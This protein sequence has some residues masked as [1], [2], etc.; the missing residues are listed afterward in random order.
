M[1]E[2]VKLFTGTSNKELALAVSKKLKIKLEATEVTKFSD[3]EIRVEIKNN[4]RGAVAFIIQ[5][6][7]APVND[8]LME[9]ILLADALRR[10]SV[11]KIIAVIPYMGYSRQDRRPGYARVPISASVVA[12]LIESVGID[13]IVTC[14]LHA[15]Q[16]Q[17]FYNIAIDNISATQL[18]VGDIYKHWLDKNAVVVS[19]DAGGVVRARAVAKHCDNLDL[20]IVDKRRQKANESEVMNIIG[21]VEN[22]TAIIVDDMCDTAGTLGKAADALIEV[23]GAKQVVA[24]ITHGVLS[25]SAIT[26]IE[27]SKL[28]ELVITN[29]IQFDTSLTKKI[30]V[31]SIATILAETVRR[32]ISNQSIS[33]FLE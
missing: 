8:S 32:I 2:N 9:L 13:H 12:H 4:V 24:Y 6:T 15:A 11:E 25:G 31:L 19:P 33:E 1:Y 14:D 5:S 7:A 23:G 3:G 16:I 22:K 28:T 18:F 26:N 17:G 21:N 10:S 27:K 29:T 30:R 20:V